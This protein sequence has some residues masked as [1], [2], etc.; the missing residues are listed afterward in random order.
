MSG[1][2]H[3]VWREQVNPSVENG[4][5]PAE[6]LEIS[7]V[8]RLNAEKGMLAGMENE[9]PQRQ[10]RGRQVDPSS[11]N[12]QM[13]KGDSH[14]QPTKAEL[15]EVVALDATFEELM[16]AMFGRRPPRRVLH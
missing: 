9:K 11:H 10:R 14:Y 13:S 8:K 4:S 15:E 12:Q 3:L 1:H 7:V 5:T 2:A 6:R 16:D